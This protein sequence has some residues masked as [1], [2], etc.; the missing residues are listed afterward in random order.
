MNRSSL[1]ATG[2]LEAWVTLR[3]SVMFLLN[4]FLQ[5]QIW[6]FCKKLNLLTSPALSSFL[7]FHGISTVLNSLLL[8]A[9]PGGMLT[10]WSDSLF[11]LLGTSSTPHTFSIHLTSTLTNLSFYITNVYAPSTP[12]LRPDFLD[13]LR[14]IIPP[15]GTPWMLSGD[16]NMTRYAHE[17]TTIISISLRLSLSMNV[18]MIYA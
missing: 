18:L 2:M 14:S 17:K 16:F 4:F 12:E 13:E 5:I 7:F 3:N 11:N 6:F 15:P 9:P 10:A 8:M 1:F